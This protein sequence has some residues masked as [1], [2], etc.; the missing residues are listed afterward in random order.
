MR[1]YMIDELTQEDI[2]RLGQALKDMGLESSVLGL[3]WLD[4]PQELL[5]EE[6][7]AHSES[8]GPHSMGLEVEENWIRMELLVRARKI[9]R[10]S[11][12]AYA[13]P[14]QREHM[15]TYLD[16]LLADLDIKV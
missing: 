8:C 2:Q 15:I 9:I 6:Q 4:V 11:C 1:G 10:C 14:E 5:S 13:T 16:S 12:V 7:A 3:Y